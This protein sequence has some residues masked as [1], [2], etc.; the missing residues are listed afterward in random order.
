MPY[1]EGLAQRIR[2]IIEDDPRI[3]EKRMFGGI[4]F[5]A[6]GNMAL[7]IIRDELMVRVGPEAHDAA[8]ALPHAR[9]MDFTGR[10]MRGFV[11]VAPAGFEDDADLRAWIQRGVAFAVTQQKK[12]MRAKAR[13]SAKPAAKK[14]QRAKPA[15]KR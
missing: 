13:K 14:T 2:E 7:G 3:S 12:P 11:Q 10:P 6:S 8:I 4:A 1:D 5:M 15:R 9:M